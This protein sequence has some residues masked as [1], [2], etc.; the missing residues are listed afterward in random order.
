MPPTLDNEP[1][2]LQQMIEGDTN[3]FKEIYE[4]YQG[5]VYAFAFRLTKTKDLAEDVVQE[6][7]TKIWEKREQIHI[8]KNF[9]GYIRQTAR[10]HIYN[11]W[12]RTAHD[13]VMLDKMSRHLQQLQTLTPDELAFRELGRMYKQAVNKLPARQKEIFILRRE[14]ELSFEQIAT[15]L[16]ISKNTVKNQMVSALRSIRKDIAGNEE[17]LIMVAALWIYFQK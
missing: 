12:T 5:I 16:G 4:F 9:G 10:N 14:Q 17:M 6:V 8:E 3:A 2:L 11:I 15:Q 13:K 1:V 7:F